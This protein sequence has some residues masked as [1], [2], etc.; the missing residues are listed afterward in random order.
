MRTDY[1]SHDPIY[2]R[3]KARGAVGWDQTPEAYREREQQLQAILASGH[4][5][6]TG[7][8]LE[9][10]CGAGN[11][12]IWLAQRG[13]TVTGVDISP[14]A[15][16]W[17]RENAAATA[18]VTFLVGDVLDL[19][20]LPD[21][22]FDLVLDGHCL[23]CIIGPDRARFLH[24]AHRLLKPGG[25]LLI[26][27]MCGPHVDPA[28]IKGYDPATR[29]TLWGDLATRYFALPDELQQEVRTAGFQILHTRLTD[30]P[31][32]SNLVIEARAL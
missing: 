2:Q 4:A 21:H 29:C 30:D 17:A 26:D 20:G 25:Y 16:Q 31:A 9:L 19:R 5:P 14:T 28:V 1:A 3:Y 13:Y 15:I 18:N 27:S 6:A 24:I 11:M 32:H 7:E 10:G 23:H 8:L 12:A 22:T